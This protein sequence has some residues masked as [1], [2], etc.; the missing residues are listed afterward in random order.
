M[1]VV[2]ALIAPLRSPAAPTSLVG[3][4]GERNGEIYINSI[5]AGPA[6]E[7]W[8]ATRERSAVT[9]TFCRDG[10]RLYC[11][12]VEMLRT[13][14]TSEQ[15]FEWEALVNGFRWQESLPA[16]RTSFDRMVRAWQELVR[17][18]A[19]MPITM[20]V[21]EA[22][23]GQLVRILFGTRARPPAWATEASRQHAADFDIDI[24]AALQRYL[25]PRMS[26]AQASGAPQG[27]RVQQLECINSGTTSLV[28]CLQ[29][30]QAEAA[31]AGI[32]VL[33]PGLW[34]EAG[35][36]ERG[37]G[38]EATLHALGPDGK[39]TMLLFSAPLLCR[40]RRRHDMCGRICC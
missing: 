33:V 38:R 4:A 14:D 11:R 3:A 8:E 24:W 39:V 30:L 5:F 12:F 15:V 23:P 35:M 29:A 37:E 2:E 36:E 32:R 6:L 18:T 28:E 26:L 13:Y 20:R 1:R 21:P 25:P 16:T 27:G 22:S 7:A 19:G 34:E 31:Q 10:S 17:Q 40:R 9:T